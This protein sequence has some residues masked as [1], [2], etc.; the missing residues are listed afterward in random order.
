MRLLKPLMST[1]LAFASASVFAA[2]GETAVVFVNG[3]NNTFDDAIASMQVLKQR[4]S[5]RGA[6]KGYVYGN[7]YNATN[8]FF[9]DLYQVFK[10]KGQE[11]EKVSGFWQMV[12][13][14]NVTPGWMS[15]AL[16]DKY[17]ATLSKEVTP[18]LPEHLKFYRQHLSA[19][20]KLV[21]VPHSQGN[22]YANISQNI[23]IGESAAQAPNV[24]AVGVAS[25]AART[26]PNSTYVTSSADAVIGALRIIKSVLPSNISQGFHPF[27][28]FLGHSFTKIY[29]DS[30]MPAELAIVREIDRRSAAPV[31]R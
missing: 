27:K 6:G 3:M 22:L 21:L 16:R 14:G 9:S 18:E 1:L 26:M 2:N 25:P 31:L 17:V 5:A 19:N 11:G 30:S 23:L 29:M 12:D 15:T 10:Q 8:G 24:F 28:D 7:A 20:R 4:V 13:G